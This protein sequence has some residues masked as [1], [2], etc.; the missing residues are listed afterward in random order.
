MIQQ[1]FTSSHS[2]ES[3]RL[4]ANILPP[5]SFCARILLAHSP[6][7]TSPLP[8]ILIPP[9]LIHPPPFL[10][11]TIM[12]S[13]ESSPFLT[14]T[15]WKVPGWASVP[16]FSTSGHLKTPTPD[17]MA[18]FLRSN[19][20]SSTQESLHHNVLSTP[21]RLSISS[22]SCDPQSI[23]AWISGFILGASEGL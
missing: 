15:C 16:S 2:L 12:V 20:G 17:N 11:F 21:Q 19:S 13:Y 3:I 10:H 18:R 1:A 14:V 8:S 5:L 4:Q 23:R 22:A 9:T 6:A 7:F